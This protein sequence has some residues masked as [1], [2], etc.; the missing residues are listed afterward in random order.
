MRDEEKGRER[1]IEGGRERE[2]EIGRYWSPG[3]LSFYCALLY[4]HFN[5]LNEK[6]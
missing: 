4:F 3:I 2:A 5:V 6:V 1:E